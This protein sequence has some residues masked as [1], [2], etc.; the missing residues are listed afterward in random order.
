MRR[1]Y[2]T[3]EERYNGYLIY[4]YIRGE[5]SR[6]SVENEKDEMFVE[7]DNV[8]EAREFIDNNLN[9]K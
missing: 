5:Y 3:L 8:E 2:E 6:Y 7:T 1:R 4:H 9:K